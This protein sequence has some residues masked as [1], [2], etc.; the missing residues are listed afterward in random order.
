M[1]KYLVIDCETGG[2]DPKKNA[3]LE[4]GA[5]LYEDDGRMLNAF[6]KKIMWDSSMPTTISVGALAINQCNPIDGDSAPV[7]AREFARWIGNITS[8]KD[9]ALLGHNLQFDCDFISI[10][11]ERYGFTNWMESFRHRKVDT[12]HIALFV[13]EA[14]LIPPHVKLSLNTLNR[15]FFG[16]DIQKHHTAMPDVEATFAIYREMR[17]LMRE[18]VS[19]D[20]TK[21]V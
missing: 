14:G 2:L 13:Q 15:H 6:N 21:A 3:L 7:V 12:Q 9:V 4:I 20:S 18:R 8:Q 11:L 1:F 10:F 16:E 17:R 19:W 5:R